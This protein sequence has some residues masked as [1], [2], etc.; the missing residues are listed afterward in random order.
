MK[1]GSV[2][3]AMILGVTAVT[4]TVWFGKYREKSPKTE[5]A[6]TSTNPPVVRC[7]STIGWVRY[8]LLEPLPKSPRPRDTPRKHELRS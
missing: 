5:P 8:P 4:G 2:V 3:L 7:R 1:P 6:P